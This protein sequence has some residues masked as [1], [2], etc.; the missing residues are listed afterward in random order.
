ML[1]LLP[2]LQLGDST[3]KP[4]DDLSTAIGGSDSSEQSAL[5][6]VMLQQLS[7]LASE[8]RKEAG[9]DG[10]ANSALGDDALLP[11]PLPASPN[12]STNSL[13]DSSD[14]L[15]FGYLSALSNPEIQRALNQL[16]NMRGLWQDL[17]PSGEKSPLA[18]AVMEVL[19][20]AEPVSFDMLRLEIKLEDL[21]F[22]DA[23]LLAI[24]GLSGLTALDT[25]TITLNLPKGLVL[26]NTAALDELNRA[27][28]GKTAIEAQIKAQIAADNT[29]MVPN[30]TVT[31][32][33]FLDPATNVDPSVPVRVLNPS[34]EL[35]ALATQ[36]NDV[37]SADVE[38]VIVRVPLSWLQEML[39]NE[40]L[41]MATPAVVNDVAI[42]D[43]SSLTPDV[44]REAQAVMPS[45]PK[46]EE[47][48]R[49]PLESPLKSLD[50]G[51]DSYYAVASRQTDL[52]N[53][54]SAPMPSQPTLKM[55]ENVL[56]STPMAP[57]NIGLQ[58]P[59]VSE[60]V[61]AVPSITA[62]NPALMSASGG[63]RSAGLL[64]LP[65]TNAQRLTS[66][67]EV[68]NAGSSSQS[69][70]LSFLL[71]TASSPAN[72]AQ[73]PDS[74]VAIM[75]QNNQ[76][77]AQ[78]LADSDTAQRRTEDD[79][80]LAVALNP[81]MA[82][83]AVGGSVDRPVVALPAINYALRHAQWET[84]LGQRLMYV[85]NQQVAQ[86]QIQL[87]PAH[88]G[89][90]RLMINFD[91]DQTV[92][93]QMQAQHSQTRDAM[94]QALP[95]LRDMLTDAGIK[96]DQLQVSQESADNNQQEFNQPWVTQKLTKVDEDEVNPI[97]TAQM[98][99]VTNQTIDFYV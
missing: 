55:A 25:D 98:P 21:D 50:N 89:P 13:A 29:A 86:A 49:M 48:L 17:P 81:T 91:R 75:A 41:V 93:I 4:F 26:A 71:Q 69:V 24:T 70:Q 1:P 64:V 77:I 38:S 53:A 94:E 40:P 8:P 18:E 12:L 82:N 60:L 61:P 9:K 76:I 74:I 11:S 62:V 67:G 22:D 54:V 85:I 23:D 5:F 52:A 47:F 19:S 92:Q 2:G 7:A 10:L 87:N 79:S 34:T 95:R 57:L 84:A 32:R 73:Q 90:I 37:A 35:L 51:R 3:L 45:A 30:T 96:F 99:R 42:P 66:M 43:Q 16:E 78:A 56:A 80:A 63:A 39:A 6:A 33:N 15:D 28:I 97:E 27:G 88:L 58:T 20:I 36:Q 31:D 83:T 14:Y 72:V 44:L 65:F 59:V 68:F 46:M